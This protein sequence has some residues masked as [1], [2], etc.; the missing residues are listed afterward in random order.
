MLKAL[1]EFLD[2][3]SNTVAISG[4]QFSLPSLIVLHSDKGTRAQQSAETGNRD[5][6]V[7][8]G[9]A[10]RWTF[11]VVVRATDKSLRLLLLQLLLLLLLKPF[12][13][14]L[15]WTTRVSRYQKDT[16]FW[17]LLKER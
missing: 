6:A 17:I 2:F 16:S 3:W 4:T 10:D 12:Y 1:E 15:S 11:V 5:K 14:P 13:D 7:D 8:D 9:W